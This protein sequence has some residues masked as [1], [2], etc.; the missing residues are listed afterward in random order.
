MRSAKAHAKKVTSSG[1]GDV[2][3]KEETAH[4]GRGDTKMEDNLSVKE[5]VSAMHSQGL[6]PEHTQ[7]VEE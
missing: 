7:G 1:G 4:S 5:Q 6:P 2:A 3:T